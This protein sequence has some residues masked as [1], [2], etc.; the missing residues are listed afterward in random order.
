M[1]GLQNNL[2][3]FKFFSCLLALFGM[4]LAIRAANVLAKEDPRVEIVQQGKSNIVSGKN[5]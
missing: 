5:W 3:Y 1:L 2:K 4:E